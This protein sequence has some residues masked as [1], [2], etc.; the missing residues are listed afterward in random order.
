MN[1]TPDRCC[2]SGALR[3]RAQ[4]TGL[5][6]LADRGSVPAERVELAR[7]QAQEKLAVIRVQTHALLCQQVA[8][9]TRI[10]FCADRCLCDTA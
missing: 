4:I 7:V 3:G 6:Q 8:H 5:L 9:T 10:A 2:L 1:L